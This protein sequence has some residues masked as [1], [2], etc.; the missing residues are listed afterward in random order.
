MSTNKHYDIEYQWDGYDEFEPI[1]PAPQSRV[2]Q[3]KTKAWSA[4]QAFNGVTTII[5][6]E[7]GEVVAVPGR[8]EIVGTY[9]PSVPIKQFRS[10]CDA[11]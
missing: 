4:I 8:A 10:D 5:K 3:S 11:T 6:R 7:D 2:A 1:K 9:D